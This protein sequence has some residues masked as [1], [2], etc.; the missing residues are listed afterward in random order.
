M[1]FL[2]PDFAAIRDAQLRDIRNQLPDAD[3][4]P[5]SDYFIRATSVG[6]AVE[7]LY[8]HQAWMVKQIFPDT[9][10]EE[11]LLQHA[12][13]RGLFLKAATAAEGSARLTGTPGTE[14]TA[15]L[16]L[17]RADG[18]SLE[19]IGSAVVAVD[20][21]AEVAVKASLPGVAGNTPAGT[22]LTLVVTPSGLDS[23]AEA[24]GLIGGTDKESSAALLARLLDVIRRPPAGG[25]RWDFRRWAL[26]V[27]GV[28]NAFSYP[29]RRGP[30]TVDVLITASDGLPS[31]TTIAAVLAHIDALRPA[32]MK[33]VKVLV[34]TLRVVDF[35]IALQVSSG[36]ATDYQDTVASQLAGWMAPLAPAD[37]VIKS[38]AE[39]LISTVPG[40]VD[41]T[42]LAPAGN[43]I[44]IN[45]DDTVEWCR[46]GSVEVVPL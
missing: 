30:G 40:V 9:A 32:G 33:D 17:K 26:E 38:Q 37:P 12:A 27:P 14:I 8:Q 21:T 2:P 3:I 25:N 41:R 43:I 23:S 1:P 39:A 18:V 34:P 13:L 22:A 19:T 15:G 4:G 29:L 45:N 20:G 10:D 36:L 28:A 5:D 44:P 35:R 31:G 6:S 24:L 16:Q 42:V 7:G 11:V 46:L